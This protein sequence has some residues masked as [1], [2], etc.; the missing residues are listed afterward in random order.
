MVMECFAASGGKNVHYMDGATN[1]KQQPT[2]TL[3]KNLKPYAA[4]LKLESNF[5][6]QGLYYCQKVMQPS[7]LLD[8]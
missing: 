1:A 4:K 8:N 3:K 5:K 2:L 6:F 7:I